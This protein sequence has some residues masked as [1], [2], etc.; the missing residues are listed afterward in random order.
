MGVSVH[1]NVD[2]LPTCSK[3][4]VT[5]MSV[6]HGSSTTRKST[7][8]QECVNPALQTVKIV[9]TTSHVRNVLI[10]VFILLK[11]VN[12]SSVHLAVHLV[13]RETVLLV[14]L[15]LHSI[16]IQIFV[17]RICLNQKDYLVVLAAS[18]VLQ[19][20]IVKYVLKDISDIVMKHNAQTV[21][22]KA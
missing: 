10:V 18:N 20:S 15:V 16:I 11:L 22:N 13:Y 4:L 3:L 1:H 7:P 2:P 12:A 17:T 21:H 9:I 8:T 19:Y 5:P 14:V 6:H